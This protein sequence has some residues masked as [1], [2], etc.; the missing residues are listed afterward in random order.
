MPRICLAGVLTVAAAALVATVGAAGGT[1]S[2]TSER[3][4][5][6]FTGGALAAGLHIART[7]R[8]QCW[9]GSEQTP[10][11]DA[12]RCIGHDSIYDPCFSNGTDLNN[13]VICVATPF[14]R[15]VVKFALTK[16]LPYGAADKAKD[17]TRHLPWVIRLTTG[18]TCVNSLAATGY[19][20]IDGM[21]VDYECSTNGALLGRP[22]RGV[23]V[24][25]PKRSTEPWQIFF[26]ENL[27]AS[28]LS[29]VGIAEA[30]W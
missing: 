19:I 27:N 30:W 28:T 7:D 17:P 8:G 24:G 11:S 14:V 20:T 18:V 25:A 15:G 29:E 12:W 5:S 10:R 23:L 16:P 21:S 6:P 3:L 9:R 22:T 26:A 13:D 4:F 1:D 2:R